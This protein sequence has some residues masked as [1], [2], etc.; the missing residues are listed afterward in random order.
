[1]D[2]LE[3]SAQSAQVNLRWIRL[4]KEKDRHQQFSEWLARGGVASP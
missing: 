2:T 3:D 1:M 4:N